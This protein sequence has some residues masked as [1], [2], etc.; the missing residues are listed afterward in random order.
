MFSKVFTGASRSFPFKLLVSLG[1]CPGA[2][3]SVVFCFI[4]KFTLLDA[5]S[6]QAKLEDFSKHWDF[7]NENLG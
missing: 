1:L 5:K 3:L 7:E 6:K 4:L 2:D